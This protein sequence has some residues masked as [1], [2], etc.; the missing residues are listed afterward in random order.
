M[1]RQMNKRCYFGRFEG[2]AAGADLTHDVL[3]I[4]DAAREA[5][6]AG[7]DELKPTLPSRKGALPARLGQAVTF[8]SGAR[9]VCSPASRGTRG[10]AVGPCHAVPFRS[11]RKEKALDLRPW[12]GAAL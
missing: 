1:L 2:R 3:Q 9:S 4:R 11:L 10:A 12:S 7:A 5:I 6:D 8:R